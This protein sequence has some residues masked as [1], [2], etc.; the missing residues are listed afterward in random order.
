MRTIPTR[1]LID[2]ITIRRS[3]QTFVPSTRKPVFEFQM[4][5]SGVRARFDPASGS[6]NR[7]VMGQT[8]KKA[9]RLFLNSTD[10]KENDEVVNEKTGVTFVVTEVRDFY[11]NHM[12]ALVEAKK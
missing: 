4:V 10:L 6:L 7:N 8:P 1:L 3:T 11:G 5:A 2:A 9:F 12:Q